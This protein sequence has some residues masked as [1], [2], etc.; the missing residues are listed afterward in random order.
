MILWRSI[1][2]IEFMTLRLTR[3]GLQV[4]ISPNACLAADMDDDG[5]ISLRSVVYQGDISLENQ[6]DS[7]CLFLNIIS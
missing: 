3:T 2:G 4:A 7:Q 1:F 6:E 5:K